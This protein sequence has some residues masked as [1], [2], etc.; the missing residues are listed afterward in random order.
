MRVPAY[1][2]FFL[3]MLILLVMVC[4]IY[5]RIYKRTI[6]RAL[7]DTSKKHKA[8]PAPFSI[9]AILTIIFLL[10]NIF[11]SYIIGFGMAYRTFDSDD[12]QIDVHAFYAEVQEIGDNTIT[13]K[14]I[15]LNEKE[16][17]E[18]LTYQLYDGIEIE[19]NGQLISLGDLNEGDMV[20]IILLTDLGGIEDIF[21]IY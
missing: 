20:S 10:F 18:V 11:L 14:G 15:Q 3:G 2:L 6:N 8:M 21:K 17:R 16:Y 4:I 9:V 5:Y 1:L 19:W 7:T 13:V 12:G